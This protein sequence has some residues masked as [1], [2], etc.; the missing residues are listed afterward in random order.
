MWII[1][2]IIHLVL[3]IFEIYCFQ[4]YPFK[5]IKETLYLDLLRDTVRYNVKTCSNTYNLHLFWRIMTTL[6][7]VIF[8]TQER[9][10]YSLSLFN[11]SLHFTGLSQYI[12]HP[13]DVHPNLKQWAIPHLQRWKHSEVLLGTV[14]KA[15]MHYVALECLLG[16][17]S[18]KCGSA[19]QN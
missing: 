1:I 12:L 14:W 4:S 11:T 13:H 5:N 9:P 8:K 16:S 17:S 7:W 6:H 15:V 3:S 10:L 2:I 18:L 19:N